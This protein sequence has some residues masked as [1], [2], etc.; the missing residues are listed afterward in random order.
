MIPLS[1][2]QAARSVEGALAPVVLAVLTTYTDRPSGAVD[3]VF[4]WSSPHPVVYPWGGGADVY[5]RDVIDTSPVGIPG[6]SPVGLVLS[7]VQG[8]GFARPAVALTLHDE[9]LPG[10]ET[11]YEALRARNLHGA[12]LELA[13]LLVDPGRRIAGPLPLWQL[14]SEPGTEHVV[15]FRGEL[16]RMEGRAADGR[17]TLRFAQRP[18]EVPLVEISDPAEADP[19]DVGAA[20]PLPV[21]GAEKVPCRSRRVGWVTTLVETIAADTTGV[22]RFSDL[23]GVDTSGGPVQALL[24]GEEVTLDNADPAAREAEITARGQGGTQASEHRAGA[25]LSEILEDEVLVAV[26][27]APGASLRHLY[28]L[29]PSTAELVRLEPGLYAWDP[30]YQDGAHTVGMVRISPDGMRSIAS[31][32]FRNAGVTQQPEFADTAVT[33]ATRLYTPSSEALQVPSAPSAIYTFDPAVAGPQADV[34]P[35]GGNPREYVGTFTSGDMS[36]DGALQVKRWRMRLRHSQESTTQF[37]IVARNNGIAAMASDTV[38]TVT[39]GVG[40]VDEAF[41]AWRTPPAGTTLGTLVGKKLIAYCERVVP[42]APVAGELRQLQIQAEVVTSGSLGSTGER[43]VDAAIVA[44]SVGFGLRFFAD[45]DGPIVP[46]DF[47]FNAYAMDEGTGWNVDEM[48]HAAFAGAQSFTPAELLVDDFE[49]HTDF[50]LATG[51]GATAT[52]ADS[53]DKVEG[54]A[55]LELTRTN[56]VG[57]VAARRNLAAAADWTGHYL[58]LAAKAIPAVPGSLDATYAS[59]GLS[60]GAGFASNWAVYALGLLTAG[61]WRYVV[62]DLDALP[63]PV[64]ASGAFNPASVAAI[65][66]GMD[67]VVTGAGDQCLFD[68]FYLVPK[69]ARAQKNDVGTPDLTATDSRYLVQVT[70]VNLAQLAGAFLEI[71]DTAGA[72]VAQVADRLDIELP[73]ALLADSAS[74]A[75]RQTAEPAGA[76]TVAAVQTMALAMEVA[77]L[78]AAGQ[79]TVQAARPLLPT[80]IVERID[81][82]LATATGWRGTAGQRIEQ[83]ADVLRWLLTDLLGLGAAALDAGWDAAAA[84]LDGLALGGNLLSLGHDFDAILAGIARESRSWVFPIERA[85]GTVYRLVTAGAGYAFGAAGRTLANLTELAEAM[86]D[87]ADVGNRLRA[88]YAYD[89]SRGTGEDAFRKVVVASAAQNDTPVAGAAFTASEAAI[90]PRRLA[91]WA[92]VLIQDEATAADVLGWLATQALAEKAGQ[93]TLPADHWEAFDLEPGDLVALQPPWLAVP[94]K[95]LVL[96]AVRELGST[97]VEISAVEVTADAGSAWTDGSAWGDGSTWTD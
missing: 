53:A 40:D 69:A 48:A 66:V 26:S 84:E 76:P 83:P 28:V 24:D 33:T 6:V 78:G 49:D 44:A 64:A 65:Q 94:V 22:V 23:T 50:A 88:F 96:G 89:G 67:G 4:Y 10:G 75:V 52:K 46:Y 71:S 27:G 51:G 7:R 68:D 12:T 47:Q 5:F 91:P 86:P 61:T 92:F 3:R 31:R 97:T 30:A 38:S 32:I 73:P 81:V 80:L 35:S 16:D 82:A 90:G 59:V 45:V 55:S 58:V 95:A 2:V 74:A 56:A 79:A 15:R 77:A 85:S 57:D 1:A 54:A 63:A 29:D 42:A 70:T 13:E 87:A 25:V 18:P 20:I 11:L 8:E 72:G 37:R 14:A 60:T 9:E 21:G 93:W 17:I 19:R 34:I 62:L 41:S 43:V 39:T 36:G